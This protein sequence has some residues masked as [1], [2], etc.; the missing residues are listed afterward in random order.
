MAGSITIQGLLPGTN[1]GTIYVGPLTLPAN[2]SGLYQET[3]VSIPSAETFNIG[4]QSWAV[5]FILLPPPTS[6]V[7]L[8]LGGAGGGTPFPISP[9]LPFMLS[10]APGT[11]GEI[12]L[13][14]GGAVLLTVIQF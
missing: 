13:T 2:A 14:S 8:A 5:G 10:L 4:F 7:T 1:A 6:A 12:T 9:N 3:N 11:P